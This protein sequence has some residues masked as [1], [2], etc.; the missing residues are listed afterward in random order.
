LTV[1]PSRPNDVSRP[2]D[3]SRPSD[4]S[5]RAGWLIVLAVVVLV[6]AAVAWG[7]LSVRSVAFVN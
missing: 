3:P 7:I 1:D 6:G 4:P 2:N 5:G